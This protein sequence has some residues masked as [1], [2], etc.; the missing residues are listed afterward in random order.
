MNTALQVEKLLM[1]FQRGLL[2]VTEARQEI[3]EL[4]YKD[5]MQND[6]QA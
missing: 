5:F 2:T 6:V 1:Q 3:M 4:L